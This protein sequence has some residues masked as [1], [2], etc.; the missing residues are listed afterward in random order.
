MVRNLFRSKNVLVTVLYTDK[1]CYVRTVINCNKC[2]VALPLFSVVLDI[3]VEPS[4]SLHLKLF[5]CTNAVQAMKDRT[6]T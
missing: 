4:T 6:A 1:M 5:Q 3:N 2:N